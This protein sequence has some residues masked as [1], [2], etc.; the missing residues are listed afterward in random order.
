M[1][2]RQATAELHLE[3]GIQYM[4]LSLRFSFATFR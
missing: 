2:P 3:H 1:N 4:L